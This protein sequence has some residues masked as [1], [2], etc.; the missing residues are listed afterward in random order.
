MRERERVNYKLKIFNFFLKL[1]SILFPQKL[2]YLTEYLSSILQG[3]GFGA[4]SITEEINACK[5]L[6]I[7]NNI[8]KCQ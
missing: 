5:K 4:F 6:F 8:N 3:K 1:L 7:N 2:F